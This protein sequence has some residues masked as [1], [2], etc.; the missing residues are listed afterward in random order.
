MADLS[1]SRPPLV[2]ILAAGAGRR[3]GQP[4]GAADLLGGRALELLQR[5]A[6]FGAGAGAQGCVVTGAHAER[7]TPLI[8]G[9]FHEVHCASWAAGR[10][11]SLAAA[12]AAHPGRDLCVAPVDVPCV[13]P[14]VFRALFAAWSAGGAPPRGWLA[15]RVAIEGAGGATTERFGHPLILGRELAAEL[16][17]SDPDRPLRDW[18][19]RA[20]PLWSVAVA[21]AAVL[22]DLD[23]P[24]DLRRLRQQRLAGA[25]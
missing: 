2:V 6:R 24:G 20:E 9:G 16:P 5:A 11:G 3:L 4:K 1:A 8:A 21:S 12:A 22:D 13:P 15:P 19:E 7:V 17:H 18:R 23:R 10:T 25:R 14:E